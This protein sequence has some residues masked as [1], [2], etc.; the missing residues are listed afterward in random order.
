[1]SPN[2]IAIVTLIADLVA[3]N[4]RTLT[5]L[6]HVTGLHRETLMT[7]IRLLK[8]RKLIRIGE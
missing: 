8:R 7:W 3:G 2:R 5:G 6:V 1:M 4:C